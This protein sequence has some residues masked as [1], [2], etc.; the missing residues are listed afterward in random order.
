MPGS[1]STDW[2]W[3]PV[4][5]LSWTG[6]SLALA[7]SRTSWTPIWTTMPV[8]LVPCAKLWFEMPAPCRTACSGSAPSR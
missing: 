8:W 1:Q 6:G 3:L 5:T 4:T 2:F 7:S